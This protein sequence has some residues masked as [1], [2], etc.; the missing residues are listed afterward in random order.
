MMEFYELDATEEVTVP[1]VSVR[2]EGGLGGLLLRGREG[3]A[4]RCECS[5]TSGLVKGV[6]SKHQVV[7]P[8]IS[9]YQ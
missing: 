7:G 3:R 6:L 4:R 9:N 5:S 1:A 8:S 2:Q